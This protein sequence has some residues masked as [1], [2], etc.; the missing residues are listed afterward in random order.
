MT[1]KEMIQ[2]LSEYA[3]EMNVLYVEDEILIRENT[4][5]LLET[6]FPVVVTASSG[7]EGIQ[8]FEEKRFDIVIT[9][10]LMPEMNGVVMIRKMKEINISQHFIVTSACEESGYL[11]ELINL[12]VAQFLLK[13]IQSEQI[14]Q[15]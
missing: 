5:L 3:K 2:Q 11:L 10:I 7:R 9:D 14:V 1:F 4:K 15:I 6:I 12:G 13:P 8:C